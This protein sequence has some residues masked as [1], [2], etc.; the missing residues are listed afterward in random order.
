[1]ASFITRTLIKVRSELGNAFQNLLL[2]RTRV[3]YRDIE[4]HIK[5]SGCEKY[6]LGIIF[7]LRKGIRVG[8]SLNG[9]LSLFYVK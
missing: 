3:L 1:M 7:I 9:N 4:I 8:G 6:L 5:I 2:F